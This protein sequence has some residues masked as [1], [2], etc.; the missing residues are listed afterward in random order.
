M[1]PLKILQKK[2]LQC[3]ELKDADEYFIY[4][5]SGNPYS[6][7]KD[8]VRKSAVESKENHAA[9]AQA[10]RERWGTHAI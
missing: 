2:C 6:W 4:K 5:K 9:R 1:Q 8:C 10:Y 3:N 7:C